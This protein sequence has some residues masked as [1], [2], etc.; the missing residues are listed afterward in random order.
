M[1]LSDVLR[2]VEGSWERLFR[3]TGGSHHHHLLYIATHFALHISYYNSLRITILFTLNFTWTDLVAPLPK[4]RWHQQ[5]PWVEWRPLP[6]GRKPRPDSHL[7]GLMNAWWFDVAGQLL[8]WLHINWCRPKWQPGG[9]TSAC[10]AK[11]HQFK[12]D[13]STWIFPLE[14]TSPPS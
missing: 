9:P 6:A 1:I 3:V 12:D 8:V 4:I 7:W 5:T 2:F 14:R 10:V 11:H 13:K